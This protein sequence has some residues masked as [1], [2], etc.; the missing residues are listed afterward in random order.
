M[1][2]ATSCCRRPLH[3]PGAVCCPPSHNRMIQN[4]AASSPAQTAANGGV[5]YRVSGKID[6]NYNYN[7]R[8][9]LLRRDVCIGDSDT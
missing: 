1:A 7:Y 5:A 2:V 3:G 9:Y 6:K 4:R 8:Q